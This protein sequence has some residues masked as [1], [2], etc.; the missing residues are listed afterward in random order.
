MHATHYVRQNSS[1]KAT[2]TAYS[3]LILLWRS[4]IIG[5]FIHCVL[6]MYYKISSSTP[7]CNSVFF[8]HSFL[9]CPSVVR[10][11]HPEFGS[12]VRLRTQQTKTYHMPQMFR[13]FAL[14]HY[15]HRADERCAMFFSNARHA[16]GG[17]TGVRFRHLN[18]LKAIREMVL[19]DVTFVNACANWTD[20]KYKSK[21]TATEDI[22]C[23]RR[24]RSERA[25]SFCGSRMKSAQSS[26]HRIIILVSI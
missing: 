23:R 25:C 18:L 12:R 15:I 16:K 22:V 17:R 13:K 9:C 10:A 4:D 6:G 2:S 26:G 20:I 24:R 11:S 14:R 3:W 1:H 21:R 7:F 8:F 5:L 19:R